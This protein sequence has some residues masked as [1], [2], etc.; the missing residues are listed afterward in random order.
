MK[1]VKMREIILGVAIIAILCCMSTV[2]YA[3]SGNLNDIFGNEIHDIQEL[4]TDQAPTNTP[5]NNI[6]TQ[7]TNTNTNTNLT[8]IAPTNTSRNTNT[9]TT[10]PKTGVDDTMMWVLIGISAVAAI[11][12][13]K[14]VRDYNV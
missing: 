3:S 11:Y 9:N 7:P 8:P 1:K 14:K 4:P 13:Y 12:T 5:A 10:L 2:N 6:V